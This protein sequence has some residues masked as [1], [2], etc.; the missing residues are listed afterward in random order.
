MTCDKDL[1]VEERFPISKSGYTVGKLMDGMECQILLD[2]GASKSLCLSHMIYI[3]RHYI[4]YQ[5]LQ[6]KHKEFK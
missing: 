3:A 5:S 1:I 2:T 6:Q 4:H